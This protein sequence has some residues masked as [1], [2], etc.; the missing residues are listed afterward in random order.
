MA[1][2]APTDQR[3][4]SKP[5][6]FMLDDGGYLYAPVYLSIRPEELVRTEPARVAVHQSLGR[7]VKGWVDDFGAGLPS[8]S[9]SGNT[10]WRRAFGTQLDG[11]ESFMALNQ[12]VAVDYHKAKQRA[13]DNGVDPATVKLLFIDMLDDFAWSVAPT[14]FILKRSKSRPLLFQYNI[15]LQAVATEIDF[16]DILLPSLGN[17]GNGLTRLNRVVETLS[18]AHPGIYRKILRAMGIGGILDALEDSVMGAIADLIG[19]FM[20]AAYDV[21][22][23]A[24]NAI[25]GALGDYLSGSLGGLLDTVVDLA[26]VGSTLF[27]SV[28]SLPNLPSALKADLGSVAASFNEVSCIFSN[29]LRPLEAYQEYSGLYGASNCSSTV[30]GRPDSALGEAN[31]FAQITR[32]KSGITMSSLALSSVAAIRAS[33]SVL[34]PMP[35][36]ELARHAGNINKGLIRL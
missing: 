14:L 30:G 1:T 15:N 29:S 13:I 3:A 17:P 26:D 27:N 10:G 35:L 9:I 22:D 36:S 6:A 32:P 7:N 12:L 4:G 11:P 33:D 5:I 25:G 24:G 28:N 19:D 20:G 18:E 8:V 16:I 23:F 2:N 21:F 34:A 31:S